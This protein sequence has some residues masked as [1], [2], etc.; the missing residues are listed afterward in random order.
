VETGDRLNDL[1]ERSEA[2]VCRLEAANSR[3]RLSRLA[4]DDLQLTKNNFKPRTGGFR[5]TTQC[6]EPGRWDH[7]FPKSRL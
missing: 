4:T 2:E 6:F 3:I 7:E 1:S 5:L